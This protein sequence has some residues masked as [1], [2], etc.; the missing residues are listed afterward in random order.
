[1][2]LFQQQPVDIHTATNMHICEFLSQPLRAMCEVSHSLY[3]SMFSQ[4]A[5]HAANLPT[6]SVLCII[7]WSDKIDLISW[8]CL[9]IS[10]RL[11]TPGTAGLC[12]GDLRRFGALQD[13]CLLPSWGGFTLSRRKDKDRNKERQA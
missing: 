2:M 13:R 6:T 11:G 7:M 8:S 4:P 3:S 5:C 12:L 1:M 9:P 10:T